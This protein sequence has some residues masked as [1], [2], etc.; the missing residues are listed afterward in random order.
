MNKRIVVVNSE[1]IARDLFEGRSNIYSDKPQSIVFKQWVTSL[2]TE[3]SSRGYCQ[4]RCGLQHGTHAVWR[5]VCDTFLYLFHG[6][7]MFSRWRLHRRIF[8]Q[9]FRPAA[10]P[11]Y[12]PVLLRNA[13]KM[14]FNILQDPTNHMSHFRML[15]AIVLLV[16]G[17]SWSPS[18]LHVH[19][20]YL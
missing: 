16:S 10:I 2:T 15:V 9:Q 3:L 19:L 7:W 5:Q 8:H 20:Y 12:Y 1:E 14:M 4:L 6:H 13:H 17:W 11:T 18:G